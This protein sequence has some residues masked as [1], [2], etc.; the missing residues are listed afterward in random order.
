MTVS[1]WMDDI[2]A[3]KVLTVFATDAVKQDN[4]WFQVFKDSVAEFNRLSSSLK[5]GVTLSSPADVKPPD[6]VGEGGAEVQFDFGDGQLQF[7]M[8]GDK[9][10]VMEDTKEGEPPKPLNF[11]P[12]ALHGFTALARVSFVKDAPG[13]I[14]RAFVF[15]PPTP[16][17]NAV[18]KVGP[19]PDDFRDAQRPAG[20]GI[21]K[22]ITVHEFI[23]AC[24]LSNAEH[25]HTG[26]DADTFTINPQLSTGSFDKPEDDKIL[27]RVNAPNP[28]VVAPPNF[29]KKKVADLIIANWK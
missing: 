18:R 8:Q 5:L 7:T 26:P 19:G 27:L 14:R 25:N 13:K 16:M 1:P 12:T 21:R 4:V 17:V 11:S 10:T 20:P 23:H 22:F 29:I 28:N 2:K 6:P 9:I 24:G 15:V 3:R